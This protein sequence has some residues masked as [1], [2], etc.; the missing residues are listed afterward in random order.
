MGPARSFTITVA[1]SNNPF[2]DKGQKS[3]RS[4]GSRSR[5]H[6]KKGHH[7]RRLSK[8]RSRSASAAIPHNDGSDVEAGSDDDNVTRDSKHPKVRG[9]TGSHSPSASRRGTSKRSSRH[10]GNES[11]THHSA[12]RTKNSASKRSG[13]DPAN[14]RQSADTA[15]LE[16]ARRGIGRQRLNA[17]GDE[18]GK[19]T[20]PGAPIAEGA[21]M[22][23]HEAVAY[24]DSVASSSTSDSLQSAD[25]QLCPELLA[26][27]LQDD[28]NN[29][30]MH[31]TMMY[32]FET[33]NLQQQQKPC[34]NDGLE[35]CC[36]C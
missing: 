35:Y 10:H 12:N 29:H 6:S 11:S 7:S 14:G 16:S 2:Q 36:A 4:R 27:A 8:H 34:K 21:R 17:G 30:G 31:H 9:S 1:P 25:G 22:H 23:G 18:P 24:C 15:G 3:P 26:L 32:P 13:R 20:G 28:Y 5:A 33:G 19:W